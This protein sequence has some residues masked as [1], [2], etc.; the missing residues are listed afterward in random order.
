MEVH[1]YTCP[2]CRRHVPK[3][4]VYGP[5]RYQAYHKD[6]V[7]NSNPKPAEWLVVRGV[8]ALLLVMVMGLWWQ[9]VEYKVLV[10]GVFESVRWG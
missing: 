8:G 3:Q 7:R 2:R 6:V 10:R 5:I 9:W 1:V 4:W